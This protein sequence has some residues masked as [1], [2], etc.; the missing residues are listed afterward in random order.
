MRIHLIAASVFSAALLSCSS[1]AG[2]TA[3]NGAAQAAASDHRTFCGTVMYGPEGG[4]VSIQ[5]SNGPSLDVTDTYPRP[6]DGTLIAGEGDVNPVMTFCM[7]GARLKNVTWKK[8]AACP[9][10][11]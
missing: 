8:V 4:C 1:H 3:G 5:Q 9:P 11:R 6:D 10:G 2:D 7:T